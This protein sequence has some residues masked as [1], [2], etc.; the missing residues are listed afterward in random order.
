[1]ATVSI[2]IPA[3]NIEDYI[4]TCLDSILAQTFTDFEVIVINDGSNDKTGSILD[5]YAAQ[6][7]RINVLHKKNE[8]V[9]AA[10]NDGIKAASGK[11]F[12]FYDG[13]DFAELNAIN[14]LLENIQTH[15]AEVIIYGYRRWRDGEVVQTCLPVFPEG[16]YKGQEIIT[17]LLSRFVGFSYD[18]LNAWLEN[19]KDGLYVE[20][21]ALWRCMINADVIRS[22]S[23]EFDTEL[24]VGEDTIFISDLLSCTTRCYVLHKCYYY[25]L[26]R[27]TSTIATYEKDAG[28]KLD[29]KTR[30]LYSRNALTQR[31]LKR[32]NIDIKG[33]WQGNIIMSD[34]E[35]A[36]LLAKAKASL[37]FFK[38]YKQYMTYAALEDVRRAAQAFK[39]QF[40]LSFKVLPFYLL[41]MRL[42]FI[43]FVFAS[44]LGTLKYEPNKL[45]R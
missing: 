25:L 36:F 38:R 30:L 28:K 43:L 21:P 27:D 9:S 17:K 37:P 3:Y 44:L 22:N 6:D 29:G 19:S 13:D 2:I 5:N 45:V 42:N 31:V 24:K 10:R 7:A 23:L 41:K 16:M 33:Y 15:N 34:I 14:E 35:L 40:K 32:N 11:Y 26:L 4:G 18:G 1:M 12:L 20:N 39:P 8:G